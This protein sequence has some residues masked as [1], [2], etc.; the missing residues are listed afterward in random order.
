MNVKENPPRAMFVGK[1]YGTIEIVKKDGTRVVEARVFQ[2]S[3][4]VQRPPSR[5]R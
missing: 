4:I 5:S 1:S 2:M 3:R